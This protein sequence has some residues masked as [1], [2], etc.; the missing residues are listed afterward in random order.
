MIGIIPTISNRFKRFVYR[1][2]KRRFVQLGNSGKGLIVL[3]KR[4]LVDGTMNFNG[5][6]ELS[7][8]TLLSTYAITIDNRHVTDLS[9]HWNYLPG[10]KV[11]VSPLA[12]SGASN[13]LLF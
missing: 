5:S 6:A 9:I 2:E 7:T 8:D 4:S 13:R 3:N 12:L 10:E 11:E 1:S